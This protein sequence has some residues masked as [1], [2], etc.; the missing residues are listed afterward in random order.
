MDL[1]FNKSDGV[2]SL[3]FRTIGQYDWVACNTPAS[4]IPIEAMEYKT[5]KGHDHRS[6]GPTGMYLDME[7]GLDLDWYDC[8]ASW[9][10]YIPL[11]PDDASE[12]AVSKSGND[13]FFDFEMSTPWVH[14]STG[15]FIIPKE[16]R[17]SID[18]DLLHLS[19]CVDEIATNHPFP[20]DSARPP[21]HDLGLLLCAFDSSE[22]LQAVGCSAKR[23]AID[24]LGFLSW[25][26]ASISGWDAEL[27][28]HIVTYLTNIQLHRFRKRGVLVDLE[29]DWRHINIS[30]LI[31]HRVPFAYLWSPALTASPRFTILSPTVLRAYNEQRLGMR[32]GVPFLSLSGLNNE[33]AV[34]L[35]F[36][37]FFQELC[38]EKRP[39]PNVEFDD[40]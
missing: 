18:E 39:D 36:D 24:Y 3:E 22:E 29:R 17:E 13:W 27:D 25:W 8:N 28:Q 11:K 12:S 5:Q 10:P 15:V 40:N 30:N 9:R 31:R 38:S 33:M 35:K 23:L 4:A 34:I 19:G 16:V 2:P 32:E 37:Q 14:L 7:W 20:F 21:P 6:K 1:L 26:T